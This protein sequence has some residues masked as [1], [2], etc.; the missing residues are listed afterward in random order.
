MKGVTT[1]GSMSASGIPNG[2]SWAVSLT[3]VAPGYRWTLTSAHS[4]QTWAALMFAT[5][6]A[7]HGN[8]SPSGRSLRVG[9]P[10]FWRHKT[11]WKPR[12]IPGEFDPAN[13]KVQQRC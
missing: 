7:Y 11:R 3:T 10:Y 12:A 13:L 4:R 5:E 6:R 8:Q 9:R 1:R 2:F